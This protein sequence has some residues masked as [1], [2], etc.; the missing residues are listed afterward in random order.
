M[1]VEVMARFAFYTK[2]LADEYGVQPPNMNVGKVTQDDLKQVKELGR[3][4]DFLEEV[5]VAGGIVKPEAEEDEADLEEALAGEHFDEDETE[6]AVEQVLEVDFE[7]EAAS[8]EA[9]AEAVEKAEADEAE[10][11]EG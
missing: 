6:T 11:E 3:I 5:C 10:T 2:A 8:E 7:A 4:A 9:E 1:R